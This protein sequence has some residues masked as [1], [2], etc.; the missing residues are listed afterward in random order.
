[1]DAR[2]TFFLSVFIKGHEGAPKRTEIARIT[3]VLCDRHLEMAE[4]ETSDWKYAYALRKRTH[5]GLHAIKGLLHE[6]VV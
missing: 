3:R 2:F 1:M 4:V 5:V 6:R